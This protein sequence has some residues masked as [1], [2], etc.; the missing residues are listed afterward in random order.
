MPQICG[1]N[2]APPLGDE[3]QI[4]IWDYCHLKMDLGIWNPLKFRFAILWSLKSGFDFFEIY[5]LDI[6]LLESWILGF[7]TPLH[8]P[9]IYRKRNFLKV[10]K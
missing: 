8:I 5:I 6:G 1:M 3:R 10:K 2:D 7:G 4:Q 9:I